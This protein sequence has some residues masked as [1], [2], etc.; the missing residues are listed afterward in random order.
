MSKSDKHKI[1]GPAASVQNMNAAGLARA[2]N[3]G[4][5]AL[6]LMHSAILDA[7]LHSDW[8][9]VGAVETSLENVRNRSIA[10]GSQNLG[11][12]AVVVSRSDKGDLARLIPEGFDY[13][14]AWLVT[15]FYVRTD[16]DYWAGLEVGD[17]FHQLVTQESDLPI[18]WGSEA[19]CVPAFAFGPPTRQ[20]LTIALSRGRPD[21]V[22]DIQERGF[23]LFLAQ[24][25]YSRGDIG[26][27]PIPFM[28]WGCYVTGVANLSDLFDESIWCPGL[29]VDALSHRLAP[30]ISK[31]SEKVGGDTFAHPQILAA[32][33]AHDLSNWVAREQTIDAIIG[34]VLG[35]DVDSYTA[36]ISLLEPGRPPYLDNLLIAFY[37][38]ANMLVQ[39]FRFA[40]S[41]KELEEDA[42]KLAQ[43]VRQRG[44]TKVEFVNPRSKRGANELNSIVVDAKGDWV[45]SDTAGF[46]DTA[47]LLRSLNWL[48]LQSGE[49]APN[50]AYL[51]P[52]VSYVHHCGAAA[53]FGEHYQPD[54]WTAIRSAL[55]EPGDP[56]EVITRVC[57]KAWAGKPE[58]LEWLL[59]NRDE[60]L[61]PYRSIALAVQF[62]ECNGSIVVAKDSLLKLLE[63][64]DIGEDCAAEFLQAG[65]DSVY[66]V[67]KVPALALSGDADNDESTYING[68][69]AQ[70]WVEDETNHLLL[71]VFLTGQPGNAD[72]AFP[73]DAQAFHLRWTKGD[74][75]ATLRRQIDAAD[76]L[77]Q[78]ALDLYAGLTLY[79]NSKDA[80]VVEHKDHSA[81]AE[82]L[83]LKNRK[84]RRKEDYLAVNS[85]IDAIHIGPEEAPPSA[86]ANSSD[87]AAHKGKKAHY[88][89][90]FVRMNQRVGPGRSQT[91]PVFIPPVLVNANKLV[92]SLPA[93]K[94]YQ[95]G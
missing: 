91:R 5:D 78:Q 89:R 2:I 70:R 94:E 13:G 93:K 60:F 39:S 40:R 61:I 41:G 44:I 66:L 55:S 58:S 48:P 74:S 42:E 76:G 83:G 52:T 9:G 87:L 3:Q 4:G 77:G 8:R 54:V 56:I 21:V 30:L 63:Q 72:D 95:I 47:C 28:L 59:A 32:D 46:G 69:L 14:L 20:N 49:R 24:E 17:E 81:A 45:A 12:R 10:R 71:D 36:R 88:R 15:L 85:S 25:G 11:A 19:L 23:D 26:A 53:A 51:L 35:D 57:R 16:G 67:V 75:L 18:Y 73:L 62:K 50:G 68:I 84:K 38:P 37:N 33:H 22:D 6:A 29:D 92:G 27:N 86:G 82:A 34:N 80:R 79:M 31:A 90:G 65:F 43:I 7:Q 1:S 64:T